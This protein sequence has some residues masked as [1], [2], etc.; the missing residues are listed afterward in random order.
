MIALIPLTGALALIQIGKG[1]VLLPVGLACAALAAH[2][3]AAPWPLNSA[4]A[5]NPLSGFEDQPFRHSYDWKKDE[6]GSALTAIMTAPMIVAQWIN[7]QYLFSTI[8]KDVWGA[9]GNLCVGLPRQ[10]L[11]RGDGVPYH[12]PR[13]LAVIVS[14]PLQRVEEI[15]LGHGAVG[16]LVE[17]GWINLVVIDPWKH[18]AHHWVRG[19][20]AAR[21]C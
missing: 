16:R 1:E 21:P 20:W 19:D 5:V 2:T 18:K 17:N 12:I 4:I 3:V 13:R 8:D 10:S 6:D 9:G 14:A 7:G 11:F 15:V